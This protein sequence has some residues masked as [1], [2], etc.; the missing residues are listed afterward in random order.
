MRIKM[1]KEVALAA[2]IAISGWKFEFRVESALES[3]Q[4][5]NYI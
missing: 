4:G 1:A 2:N 5:D 3:S